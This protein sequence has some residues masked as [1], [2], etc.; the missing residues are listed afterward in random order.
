MQNQIDLT[1]IDNLDRLKSMAYDQMAQLE[2]IQQNL[3]AINQRIAQLQEQP[4][5][6]TDAPVEAEVPDPAT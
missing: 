3:R 2:G 4:T 1:T 6:P 5:A